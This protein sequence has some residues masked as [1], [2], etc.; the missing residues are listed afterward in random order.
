MCIVM[1]MGGNSTTWMNTAVL[2][3]C[4]RNFRG[5]RGPVSGILKAYVG[6]STAIFTDLCTSLFTG[7]AAT[8]VLMLALIPLGICFVAMF[9][10]RPVETQADVDQDK[11]EARFFS[12]L[13]GIAIVLALYLLAYD[14]SGI[15]NELFSKIIAGGLCIILVAP[16][17]LPVYLH[18]K[19]SPS[20]TEATL[21]EPLLKENGGEQVKKYLTRSDVEDLSGANGTE[22]G[23]STKKK[24]GDDHTVLEALK[25]VDFWLL[26]FCFLC[27]V[28]TGMA[29]INNM[30]Q[31]GESMGYS[32]VSVFVS[33]ISIWG[34]FGR[35][36]SGALS[37]FFIRWKA[38]P[39]PVLLAAS[40][41]VMVIG[42]VL[43]AVAVPGSVYI[44]SIVV[45]IC[46]GVRLAVSVP[47]ASE[48][49][50]LKIFGLMYNLLILNLPL[51]SFLFSSLLSG[52]LYDYEA[53]KDGSSTTCLGA[54]C[55][56]S[57]FLV[58]ASVSVVGFFLD[59]ILT[60][61]TRSLYRQIYIVKNSK[62]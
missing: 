32:N 36:G 12:V 10:L 3:T 22:G 21:T 47:V 6:L 20:K 55:Y 41:L 52:I 58:M 26:F 61:R 44:G 46:Y 17:A 30:G 60:L 34:F 29:V 51:G 62:S 24:L 45:G 37:E 57:V 50:G 53:A 2:V 39:R 59:S 31:I 15:D 49:F 4:I 42:Y 35:L 48:M 25:S 1:C 43:L 14:L 18:F 23:S 56:R 28:G 7:D 27:G 9:L 13:D 5:N 11:Q 33:L 38:L 16:L 8:F 19:A 54:H 40:Q